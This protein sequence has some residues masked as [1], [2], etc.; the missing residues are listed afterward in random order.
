MSNGAT[1][2]TEAGLTS[3]MHNMLDVADALQT[4]VRINV[5]QCL[6]DFHLLK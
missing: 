5:R 1:T 3:S 2:V 6:D 4:G